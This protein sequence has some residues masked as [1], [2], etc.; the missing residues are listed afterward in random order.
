[1]KS[2]IM[3]I[4]LINIMCM[5]LSCNGDKIGNTDLK[6]GFYYGQN[7]G[8]FPQ[9]IVYIKINKD[10]AFV[11]CYLP[12]KCEYFHTFSDTLILKKMETI[13]YSSE[14][15]CIYSKKGKLFFKTIKGKS[16]CNVEETRITYQPDKENEFKDIRNKAK[17][18]KE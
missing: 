8:F 9:I 13:L 14:K 4:L 16:E 2:V 5:F 15:S 17:P 12:L 10:T 18:F 1:M 11:E 7:K 6:D 3:N